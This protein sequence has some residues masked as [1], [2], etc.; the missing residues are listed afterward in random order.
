MRGA[1]SSSRT[2]IAVKV[3][4][5]TAPPPTAPT[6]LRSPPII[7]L[8]IDGV[9]NRTV[10]NTHIR[11]DAD[12]VARLRR[13]CERT[14]AVIVLS[15][16]WREFA[17]YIEYILR[18]HGVAAPVVGRTPGQAGTPSL[19]H[20][21]PFASRAAE[22]EAYLAAQASG[23]PS[24]PP[25][26][27]VILDD[28]PDA[29]ASDA[30]RRH[31]VRTDP[32]VGLTDADVD[33][34]VGIVLGAPRP[35]SE[36]P[37]AALLALLTAL[38]PR[39]A[40]SLLTA[41]LVC[42]AW[43]D[44]ARSELAWAPACAR[45]GLRLAG[46]RDAYAERQRRLGL[47]ERVCAAEVEYISAIGDAKGAPKRRARKMGKTQED[48]WVFSSG[49]FCAARDKR[50]C[51]SVTVESIGDEMR[52]GF[53]TDPLTL[54]KR[55]T[56][57]LRQPAAYLYSDGSKVRGVFA[58]GRRVSKESVQP[59]GT[60][61]RVAVQLD[62][63]R[64]R[65]RWYRDG[66]HVF[67]LRGLPRGEIFAA[68]ALAAAGDAVTVA[69]HSSSYAPIDGG[70][71]A[72]AAAAI[73]QPRAGPHSPEDSRDG[74]DEGDGGSHGSPEALDDTDEVLSSDAGGALFSESG[75]SSAGGPFGYASAGAYNAATDTDGD[76]GD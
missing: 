43:R 72:A 15:T 64:D 23:R 40:P 26:R 30:L 29:G 11:L 71:R 68:V 47:D 75:Y 17:G 9:L 33:A 52:V 36:L 65:A 20:E 60:G 21:K 73:A 54:L 1:G 31:F 38:A 50:V 32:A 41:S 39:E 6:P 53:T 8:D 7:F 35:L 61:S 16:F 27:F 63:E 59:F 57:T 12:L 69:P 18:R 70:A 44:V 28:R 66:V 62:F 46:G 22:I 25:P 14:G 19:A 42:R 13:L 74:E 34:A 24:E 55:E 4:A 58:G 51:W 76:V 45:L 49:G 37:D 3:G 56:R 48:S 5:P 10:K 2:T 67:T